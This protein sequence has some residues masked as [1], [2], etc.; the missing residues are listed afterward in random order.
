MTHRLQRLFGLLSAAALALPCLPLPSFSAATAAPSPPS[1]YQ[2]ADTEVHILRAE[3]LGRDYE[4]DISLP[5]GYAEGA[6][7][8]PVV[9]VT[10]APYAFP[11]L[12][13]ITQRITRHGGPLRPFILVGLGYARGDSPVVSR[14]RDYTPSATPHGERG[15]PGTGPYGEA[16]GYRRFVADQ[17]LPF[18]AAH[19]RTDL[20]TRVYIGHSYGSLFGLDALLTQP[21]LFSHYILGSP[22]LWFDQHRM[23]AR[24]RDRARHERDLPAHVR[25]FVGG[26]ETPQ[27]GKTSGADEDD[28][29]GDTRALLRQLRSRHYPGLDVDAE[30]FAGED[31]LTVFPRLA[32]RGLLW[33]LPPRR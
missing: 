20:S 24:E 11:L 32:T 6:Q 3:R 10:D 1:P 5:D 17:V 15:P 23:L 21:G 28:M 19:Y 30:V 4:L 33:A 18:V 31:H 2:L 27:H 25:L 29:V 7:R 26:L 16:E 22:S 8:Y 12:R 9:F 14:N 13:A